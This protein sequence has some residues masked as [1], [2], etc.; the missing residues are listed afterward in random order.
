M[1]NVIFDVGRV[2]INWDINPVFLDLL[3]DQSAVDKFIDQVDFFSWNLSMDNGRTCAEAV[4]SHSA[5]FPQYVHIFEQFDKRW[6]ETVPT[7]IQHSVDILARLKHNNIPT[8]AITNFSAEKWPIACEMYPFLGTSF[9]DTI[10]SGEVKLIKPG[11][12]I[13]ELL[14]SRNNLPAQDCIFIDDS[15]PNVDAAN[16]LGID[17]LLFTSSEQF[18]RDLIERGIL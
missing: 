17:G 7:S 8:Y 16:A 13:F 18:E 2:L 12:E 1:K 6:P 4:A 14:L 3:G 15:Q 11:K 10:V 5:L 9:I